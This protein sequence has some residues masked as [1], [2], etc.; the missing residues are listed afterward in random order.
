MATT[1]TRRAERK[2]AGR[3]RAGDL[4]YPR[5]PILTGLSVPV[6]A[7][8][9]FA[10]GALGSFSWMLVPSVV[11]C[12]VGGVWLLWA[13]MSLSP[14]VV[15]RVVA[16]VLMLIPMISAPLSAMKASQALALQARGVS[17]PAVITRIAVHHGK[18]TTYGCT[19][20]YDRP[21]EPAAD[22][23]TEPDA[24]AAATTDVISCGWYDRVGDR[25]QVVRD[26]GGLVGPE[27]DGEVRAAR[28]AAVLAA[29]WETALL[30]VS[31]SAVAVGGV[32]HTVGCRRV[33]RTRTDSAYAP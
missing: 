27:F 29:G 8:L 20:H 31:V 19:V 12:L 30:A 3:K 6:A 24:D 14:S 28:S 1:D 32:M 4:K 9:L 22:A 25:V 7:L 17:R 5:R 10:G 16:M 33:R 18:T 13:V 2:R 15:L 26:P 23:A 11:L 21:A